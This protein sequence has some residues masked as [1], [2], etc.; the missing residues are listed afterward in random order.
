M[1]GIEWNKGNDGEGPMA[2]VCGAPLSGGVRYTEN[3]PD[4]PHGSR[5]T[6]TE[7]SWGVGKMA[8]SWDVEMRYRG[9]SLGFENSMW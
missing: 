6:R 4:L 8:K 3:R 1:R 2:P 5:I 9:W 7:I